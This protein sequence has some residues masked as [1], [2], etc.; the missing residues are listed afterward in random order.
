[1]DAPLL[2]DANKTIPTKQQMSDNEDDQKAASPI[3]TSGKSNPLLSHK[4]HKVENDSDSDQ[5]EEE[6][7]HQFDHDESDNESDDA[8][9][10]QNSLPA[11]SLKVI[12]EIIS[13]HYVLL[14]VSTVFGASIGFII[15]LIW[16]YDVWIFLLGF[17]G[18]FAGLILDAKVFDPEK[19]TKLMVNYEPTKE[20]KEVLCVL[21]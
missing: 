4:Q 13:R 15:Y 14:F 12:K 20:E 5:E 2:S 1:M 3:I 11:K 19:R 9:Y 6:E 17:V 16:S 7:K 8:Y 18:F 21:I 10:N